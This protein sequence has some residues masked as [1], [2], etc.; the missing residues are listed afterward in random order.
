MDI[1]E[2]QRVLH[3]TPTEDPV[4]PP[5]RPLL[6]QRNDSLVFT[7][8][9]GDREISGQFWSDEGVGVI[10][11]GWRDG[12][13]YLVGAHALRPESDHERSLRLEQGYYAEDLAALASRH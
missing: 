2:T 9:G 4:N 13:K 8:H 5:Q 10:V 3:I 11:Y 1:G 12:R 6:W 7:P